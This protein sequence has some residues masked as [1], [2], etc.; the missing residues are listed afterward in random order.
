M[1]TIKEFSEIMEIELKD[2]SY[3]G[4]AVTDVI[5]YKTDERVH[6]VVIQPVNQSVKDSYTKKGIISSQLLTAISESQKSIIVM[7]EKFAASK[8]CLIELDVILEKN[9]TNGHPVMP[10]FYKVNPSNVRN[11]EEKFAQACSFLDWAH[12]HRQCFQ[13]FA[14]RQHLASPHSMLLRPRHFVK[15]FYEPLKDDEYHEQPRRGGGQGPGEQV[16]ACACRIWRFGGLGLPKF[17]LQDTSKEIHI[18]LPL[19]T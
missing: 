19:F 18:L 15:V 9:R 17:L 13:K 6:F 8:W 14:N 1:D 10:I 4:K 12:E 5:K 2:D 3:Q 16:E 11:Q 7:S